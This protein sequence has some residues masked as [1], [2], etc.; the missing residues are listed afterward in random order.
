MLTIVGGVIGVGAKILIVDVALLWVTVA[1]ARPSWLQRIGIR[2]SPP[3][4]SGAYACGALAAV[5]I[6]DACWTRLIVR[7]TPA[8]SDP[9]RNVLHEGTASIW[10]TGVA[11]CLSA[12]VVE[13]MFFRG[14]LYSS[15]RT[16]MKKGK[17]ALI[18]GILFGLAH[19]AAY[20][21]AALPPKMAFGVAMCILY[22]ATGSILPGIAVHW[23]IDASAF[24]LTV[25]HSDSMV[26]MTVAVGLVGGACVA[27]LMLREQSRQALVAD[28][29]RVEGGTR[30]IRSILQ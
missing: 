11:V 4:K 8:T 29:T 7:L 12:P 5:L 26:V 18:N 1:V 20:P 28:G 30:W 17:A 14:V 19:V 21:P 16:R 27:L 2:R 9:L 24:D 13:E 23:F 10:L 15:L 25:T 6:F 3:F 22:E